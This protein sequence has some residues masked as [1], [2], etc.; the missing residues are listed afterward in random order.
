[1]RRQSPIQAQPF[2]RTT[3]IA[4]SILAAVAVAQLV[5]V[6]AAFFRNT[7]GTLSNGET[8]GPPLKIDV[9]KIVAEN[10]PPEPPPGIGEDPIATASQETP[11]LPRAVP[12]EPGTMPPR[13]TPVPLNAFT[14]KVDVRFTELIEQGKLLR[15][16]GDTAGALVK[17]REAAALDPANALPIAEQAFTFEKMSLPDKAA[18]QWRRI[19]G[20]GERA[21]VYYSAARSKLEHAVQ[22]TM[23]TPAGQAEIPQGKSLAIGATEITDEADPASA[24]K[25]ALAVPIRSRQGAPVSVRDLKLFVLFYDRANGSDIVKTIADVSNRWTSPPADWSEGDTETLEV[26]YDLSAQTAKGERREYYGYIV[27]LYY[28]GELQDTKAE[29][30]SLNQKFPAPYTLSE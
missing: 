29:P 23:R 8:A 27:R 4:G 16:S 12:V 2:G 13:P 15:G 30:A 1:M 14:P 22:S 20:M 3:V 6:T 9:S 21:G 25:F 19:I 11:P 7:R 28:G 26:T 24:K 18:E 5:A 17:F 10:P